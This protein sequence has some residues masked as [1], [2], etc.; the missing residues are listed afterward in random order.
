LSSLPAS[1]LTA[2]MQCTSGNRSWT[3]GAFTF[4]LSANVSGTTSVIPSGNLLSYTDGFATKVSIGLTGPSIPNRTKFVTAADD[5]V[6]V[7]ISLDFQIRGGV[8]ASFA[9]GLY[10]ISNSANTNDTFT[11]SFYKRCKPS[12]LLTDALTAAFSDF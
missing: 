6:Y 1:L 7:C 3:L 11:I 2:A 12:D 8:S 5:A 9:Q 10:G 4:T